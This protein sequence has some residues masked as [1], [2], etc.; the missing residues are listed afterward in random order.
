M[1]HDTARRKTFR[2][3][4]FGT[5]LNDC[6]WN[7]QEWNLDIRQFAIYL[8]GE[9]MDYSAEDDL[10]KREE[11]GVEYQMSARFIKNLHILADIDPKRSILVHM[12]TDGG[13]WNEGMAIYDAIRYAP[14]PVV[15]LNYTHARSMSSI[16]FQA[17]DRR[18]MMP[19]S[20][21]MFHEGTLAAADTYKGFMSFAEWVK[22]YNSVMLEIY[23]NQMKKKGKFS[24]LLR[25]DIEKMLQDL[26]NKKQEK[27]LTSQE[28]VEW[29]LADDIF[30]GDWTKLKQGLKK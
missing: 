18:V 22:K 17:A 12:K 15:T 29:G 7:V 9:L 6:I 16:I 24:K 4:A 11:P 25:S 26:M 21:F 2:P 3:R 13:D 23:A 28:A 30:D 14:N 27:Y 20:D 10:D 5:E 8:T 19:H 1:A